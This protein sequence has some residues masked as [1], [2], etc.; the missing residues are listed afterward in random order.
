MTNIQIGT[1]ISPELHALA[2][3]KDISWHAA[4]ARGVRIL[5]GQEDRIDDELKEVIDGN[6]KLQNRL[7]IMQ[8]RIWDLEQKEKQ[9]K[10]GV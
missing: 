6:K 2:R 3:Q 9:Q 1:T 8:Q 7:T 10:L 4:L 5:A